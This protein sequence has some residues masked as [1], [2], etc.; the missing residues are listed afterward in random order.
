MMKTT[1]VFVAACIMMILVGACGF[2]EGTT[3]PD[4][5]SYVWFTG[6]TDGVVAIIDEQQRIDLGPSYYIDAQGNKKAKKT[7]VHY[8]IE[9]G[10]HSVRLIRG[11]E[12]IL[13]RTLLFGNRMT[14]EIQIP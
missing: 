4:S 9:P 14:T 1:S 11:G 12:T 13:E 7:P 5:K 10:K 3:L 2:K 6:K 8:E